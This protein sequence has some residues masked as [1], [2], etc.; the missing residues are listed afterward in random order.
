V[1]YLAPPIAQFTWCLALDA[2]LTG[3]LAARRSEGRTS[4]SP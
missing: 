4:L 3:W 1:A 2:P